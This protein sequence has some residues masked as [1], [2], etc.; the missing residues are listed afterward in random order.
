MATTVTLTGQNAR[1]ANDVISFPLLTYTDALPRDDLHDISNGIFQD[2]PRYVTKWKFPRP[3]NGPSNKTPPPG[4]GATFDFQ[5]TLPP[6]EIVPASAGGRS[7][8]GYMIGVA[9]GSP[10]LLDDQKGQPPPRFNTTI[11]TEQKG[12]QTLPKPSKWKKIGGLFKA[13]NALEAGTKEKPDK[14]NK[15]LATQQKAVTQRDSL[16]EWPKL[17]VDPARRTKMP[18]NKSKRS[19]RKGPQ[20]G[21]HA[22]PVLDVEI[23]DVQMERYSV[24]FSQVMN[25]DKRP[26]LLS[27][28]SKTLDSL[29]VPTAAEFLRGKIPPVPQRRATSP[30]AT[31]FSLFPTSQPAKAAKVLGTQNFSRG[32]NLMK[33]VNPEPTESPVKELPAGQLR[34]PAP[35]SG[36]SPLSSSTSNPFSGSE[37]SNTPQSNPFLSWEEK[38]LPAIKPDKPTS[39]PRSR[40]ASQISD[41]TSKPQET[42]TRKPNLSVKTQA[43]PAVPAKDRSN[44]SSPS[45]SPATLARNTP[46]PREQRGKLKAPA[47]SSPL[48]NASQTDRSSS[49]KETRGRPSAV[50]VSTARSV[51][52]SKGKKQMLVP[53]GSRIDQLHAHERY[54]NRQRAL[55]P[56]I[57]GGHKYQMSQELQIESL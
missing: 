28:R 50:Q 26:S 29:H 46:S 4:V 30:A 17:E 35:S 37:R 52:V 22:G 51:S 13:K 54:V 43:G 32:P 14:V 15:P 39:R 48:R 24:M 38:P 40:T 18:A 56:Q 10:R 9:L 34:V 1:N 25:K 20:N 23:P 19:E 41:P 45:A 3:V 27:R 53:V 31:N 33:A 16:E 8:S 7:P 21:T 11:F 5:L 2:D 6:D 36:R 47:A 57:S 49:P 55:T 12:T 42:S 44:R